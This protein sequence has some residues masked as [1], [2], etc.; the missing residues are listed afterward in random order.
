MKIIAPP[1][2]L[3]A[4]LA[5]GSCSKQAEP[6]LPQ[7]SQPILKIAVSEQGE[8]ELNGETTSLFELQ[9]ELAAAAGTETS[10]WYYRPQGGGD[11][12]EEAM[13]V[14]EAILEHRLP[15]SL[16]SKPDFSTVVLPDGS[17]KARD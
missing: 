17:V 1:L 5:A 15:V 8:I 3:L 14:F 4:L 12:P 6:A 2:A 10:V 9:A 13:Q 7:P 16:S 11:P